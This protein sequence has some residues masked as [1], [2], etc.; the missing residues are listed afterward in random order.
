MQLRRS[1][2]AAAGAL[3]TAVLLAGCGSDGPTFTITQLGLLGEPLGQT[4]A[5]VVDGGE[6]LVLMGVG[7]EEGIA[8]FFDGVE[9]PLVQ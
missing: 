1:R 5:G 3:L 8:V 6:E 2:A 9:S 4:A 7:F